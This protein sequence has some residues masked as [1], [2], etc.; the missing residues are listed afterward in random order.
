MV[1]LKS[2]ESSEF[3]MIPENEVVNVRL[4]SVEPN[5]FTWE[6]KKVEK[7]RWTFAIIDQ[8]EWYGKQVRGDTSTSF[9]NHPNCRAYNWA[10]ALAGRQYADGELF[11]SDD[12]IGMPGRV[13][14]YHKP[15]KRDRVWMEVK[16]VLPPSTLKPAA[17]LPPDEAPF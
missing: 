10:V 3:D 12:I 8:G 2:Q 11:D 4:E 17:A 7:L 13:I 9:T 5:D 16:D 1:K 15:D 14:I 6:G